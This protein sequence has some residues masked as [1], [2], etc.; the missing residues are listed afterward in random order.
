MENIEII[1]PSETP[2][3]STRR[4]DRQKRWMLNKL[5]RD[6]LTL[7][8]LASSCTCAGLVLNQLRDQPLPLVYLSKQERLQKDI[9]QLDFGN[10]NKSVVAENHSKPVNVSS[11]DK[12]L[13]VIELEEFRAFVR[14]RHGAVLD[15]RP[16]IFY[17]LGNVPGAISLSREQ[18]E[19]DYTKQRS[20]LEATRE[21]AVAVYCS[22]ASC[23]DSQM[24]AEALKK[25]GY[26]Q[27]LVFK[28]GWDEWT[29]AGL[30][31]EKR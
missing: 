18:F 17:R 21:K 24:V 11:S 19:R 20:L 6:L 29:Q 22:S 16:E 27:V 3:A 7:T 2:T 28:G 15:A 31:E 4:E 10:T 5:G 25:L 26:N 13:R 23:E 1:A 9:S 30:P 8:G 14:D 12:P